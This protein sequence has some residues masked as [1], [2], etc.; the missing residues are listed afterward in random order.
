[1]FVVTD[2]RDGSETT[3]AVQAG[4]SKT[5]VLTGFAD[6]EH[7][8]GVTAD[9]EVLDAVEVT[10]DCA[11]PYIDGFTLQCT[12]GGVILTLGNS[13]TVPVEVSI[14]VD[15]VEIATA[16]I[17]AGD[18]SDIL[19]PLDEDQKATIK[20]TSGDDVLVDTSVDFDCTKPEEPTTTTTTER[21]IETRVLAGGAE[22]GEPRVAGAALPVTG[23]R[24]GLAGLGLLLLAVGG[25]VLVVRR[26][27]RED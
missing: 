20:V 21:P 22:L 23:S 6:G 16:T 17:P 12:E 13:G 11:Q 27:A 3:E 26:H 8:I 24:L 25:G 10:V 14:L 15:D 9:G 7:A 2:P 1:V 18:V 4:E 19:I 5:V